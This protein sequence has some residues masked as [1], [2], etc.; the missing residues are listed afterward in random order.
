MDEPGA[1]QDS[2]HYREDKRQGQ[3]ARKDPP[4]QAFR[5]RGARL[6]RGAYEKPFHDAVQAN[7]QMCP[8][9]AEHRETVR[10]NLHR[11]H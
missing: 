5:P 10:N 1:V 9:A 8:G 7:G 2:N 3:F 6:V 4:H 11:N